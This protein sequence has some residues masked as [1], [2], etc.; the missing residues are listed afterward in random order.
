MKKHTLWACLLLAPVFVACSDVDLSDVDTNVSIPVKD[1]VIPVKMDDVKLST[2]LDVSDDSNLREL[3]GDYAIVFEGNYVSD[4]INIPPF[5]AQA[6]EIDDYN[7]TMTKERPAARKANAKRAITADAEAVAVYVLPKAKEIIKANAEKVSEAIRE[8]KKVEANTEF[9]FHIKIDT[10]GDL[11]KQVSAI[12]IENFTLQIPRGIVGE[13]VLKNGDGQDI[14]AHYSSETGL[15]S[16]AGKNI[17]STDGVLNLHITVTAFDAA[18]L[19]EALNRFV[20]SSNGRVSRAAGKDDFTISESFG[21]STGEI[22]VYSS[23]FKDPSGTVDDKYNRLANEVGYHSE[24]KMKDIEVTSVSGSIDYDVDPFTV[25]DIKLDEVPDV[26][27][28]SGTNLKI[29]NP[30][31]YVYFNNPVEDGDGHTITASTDIRL[32]AKDREGLTHEYELDHN[33]TIEA[34]TADNYFYLSPETVSDTELYTGYEGAKHIKFTALSDVLSCIVS[35]ESTEGNGIPRSISF[36]TYNTHVS[37]S[38]VKN[39]ELDKDYFINGRY[40]FVAPLALTEGSRIKYTDTVNGWQS[41]IE[42]IVITEL[43]ITASVST[44]V[45]F[46]LE[47]RI[48]PIDVDGRPLA[49]SASQTVVVPANAKDVPVSFL[50]KGRI[51]GLDGIKIDAC[52]VAKEARTLQPGMNISM[53]NLKVKVSGEYESEL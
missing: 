31:I 43:G 47:F 23:D 29:A 26:L 35:G 37:G 13:I 11:F 30:Q 12:H 25:D 18:A 28:E 16:F 27:K 53:S 3:N 6:Q 2:M 15:I 33:Q 24:G 1:M 7:G 21:V 40:A 36:T 4:K 14:V 22:V 34:S 32:T 38:D 50:T 48:T 39:L 41:S 52:A 10:Y 45:P 5:T 17:V 42:G 8:L 44:D 51:V 20:N 46:E 9:D 49:E 19:E